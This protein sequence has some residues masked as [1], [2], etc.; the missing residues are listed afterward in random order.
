MAGFFAWLARTVDP[1][2]DIDEMAR[3]L[4]ID[5]SRILALQPA[6]HSFRVS[7]TSGG[8]RQINAP[9]DNLKLVQRRILRR[10]LAG[11]KTHPCAVGFESG[12]SIVTHARE[13]TGQ[14]VVIRLDI[15]SFFPNTRARRVYDY[16][17]F[18]GWNRKASRLLMKLVTHEDRLPQGAPTSPRLSNLLNYRMDARLV[19]MVREI[20]G[21]TARYT[22]YAD[23]L[24][25]SLE[26]ADQETIARVIRS[27][28]AITRDE[29]YL[30]HRKKKTHILR[31][32]QRQTVAG[33]VV[34]DK[35][36]LPRTTRRWLRAVEHHT[37]HGRDAT[38]T[39]NQLAGW[40]SLAHM[41]HTQRGS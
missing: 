26:Q 7:K 21:T 28:S 4:D 33:L 24:T 40:R 9:D 3:R 36:D 41:I 17:R 29:G 18:I 14:G 39:P 38:L 22:R 1:G 31:A 23:D 32:H 35:V 19:A 12:K 15:V 11:L 16:F 13:H 34:N 6:Y 37:R 8:W 2:H 30:L 20:G 27:A 25:F 10:L 5:A